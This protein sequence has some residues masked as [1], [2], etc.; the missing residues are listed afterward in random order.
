MSVP[1]NSGQVNGTTRD[2]EEE[3]DKGEEES[4]GLPTIYFS[5]TVEPKKVSV[6]EAY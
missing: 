6:Y 2:R 5:H 3:E 4:N 1:H